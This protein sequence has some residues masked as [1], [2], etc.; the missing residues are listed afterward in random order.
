MQLL[1]RVPSSQA[2]TFHWNRR[3]TAAL[4]CNYATKTESAGF[5]SLLSNER[6]YGNHSA[7]C[8]WHSRHA[9]RSQTDSLQAGWE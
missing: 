7:R 2:R 6:C 3:R 8:T 9:E 1:A 5:S 4:H